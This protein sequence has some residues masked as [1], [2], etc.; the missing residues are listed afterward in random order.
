MAKSSRQCKCCATKYDYCPTCSRAD[1]LKPRW[2]S[3]F[4]SE[5]CMTLW[6]TATKYNMGRVTKEEAKEIIS[7]LNLKP[8]ESYAQCVQRDLSVIMAKARR[9]KKM[10]EPAVEKPVL[11]AVAELAPVEEPIVVEE[12][13]IAVSEVETETHEVVIEE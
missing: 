9:V 11:E 1:A 3:T 13:L 2:F 7:N 6:T 12:K 5:E 10:V 8:V 4:C